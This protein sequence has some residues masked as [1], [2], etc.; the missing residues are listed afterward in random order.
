MVIHFT[1][2]SSS[3]KGS[4]L[5]TRKVFLSRDA[6]ADFVVDNK[7]IVQI[8]PEPKNYYCWAV[9]DGKGRYGVTNLNSI[10]IEMCSQLKAGTPASVP[11]HDGWSF[12][13]A[14]VDN[15]V[16]L[17]KFLIRKYNIP[18][19]NVIRHYDA[20]KKL[21]PGVIGWNTGYVYSSKTGKI[22][23]PH[24]TEEKWQEFKSRLV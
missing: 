19:E 16:N 2:G 14:V 24:N 4:A 9:G 5:S 3:R 20:S 10:H 7:T 6:S 13:D 21:C 11:N 15:T 18:L 8:N 23:S 17:T 1:A 12:T 22:I